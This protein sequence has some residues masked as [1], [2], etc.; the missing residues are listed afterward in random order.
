MPQKNSLPP[1]IGAEFGEEDHPTMVEVDGSGPQ[2]GS[3]S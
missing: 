1:Y 2:C 3:F